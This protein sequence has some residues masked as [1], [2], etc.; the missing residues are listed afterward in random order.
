MVLGGKKEAGFLSPFLEKP[1]IPSLL[2]KGNASPLTKRR[3][4]WR[5]QEN[6]KRGGTKI[7]LAAGQGK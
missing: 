7:N 5:F 3:G 4:P 2:K 1:K 6:A